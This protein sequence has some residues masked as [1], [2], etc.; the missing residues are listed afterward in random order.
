MSG[1]S[2]NCLPSSGRLLALSFRHMKRDSL[3]V[4]RFRVS[5]KNLSTIVIAILLYSQSGLATTLVVLVSGNSIVFGADG[6]GVETWVKH[7][8]LAPIRS[9]SFD[10]IMIINNR[11]VVSTIGAG[12]I[13][14][15]YDFNAWI[16]SLPI[17]NT[18]S[19]ERAAIIIK[20]KCGPVF[21]SWWNR[22]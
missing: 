14:G 22:Q 17:T 1:P 9:E 18:T 10:K 15:V 8:H 3:C 6:K 7:S 5:Y 16:R 11:I 12:R 19:V 4:L 13:E 20:D 21:T 2:A